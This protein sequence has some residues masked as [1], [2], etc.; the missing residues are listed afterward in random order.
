MTSWLKRLNEGSASQGA[1]PC[2]YLE[3]GCAQTRNENPQTGLD[4]GGMWRIES[5]KTH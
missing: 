4:D 3:T 1:G 5:L 2:V